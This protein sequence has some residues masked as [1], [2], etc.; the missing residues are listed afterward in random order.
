MRGWQ[1]DSLPSWAALVLARQLSWLGIPCRLPLSTV[2]AIDQGT[3]GA[4]H[5]LTFCAA[6]PSQAYFFWDAVALSCSHVILSAKQLWLQKKQQQL[7][8]TDT[9]FGGQHD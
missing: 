7:L 3:G 9:R 5:Q 8:V 2:E 1:S 6:G 4:L